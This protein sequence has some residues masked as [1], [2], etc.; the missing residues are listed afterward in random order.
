MALMLQSLDEASDFILSL[1]VTPTMVPN[2]SKACD[3]AIAIDQDR[4]TEFQFLS[5]PV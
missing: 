3:I 5:S 2:S 1:V 4:W